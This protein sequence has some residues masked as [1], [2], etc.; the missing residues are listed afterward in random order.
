MFS[1]GAHEGNPDIG[2]GRRDRRMRLMHGNPHALD[3]PEAI[4]NGFGD[5]AGRGLDEP[6]AAGAKCL[7]RNLDDLV[8]AHGMRELIGAR[9]LRQ[10]D[11]EHEVEHKSL[12]DLRLMLHDAVIGMEG[13]SIDE[14]GVRHCALRTAAATRSA[15][16]VAATSWV[17]MID[18]PPATASR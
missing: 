17:R 18:A 3:L 9:S 2:K 11:V 5:R 16:T 1:A 14:H 4:E 12:P 10:I 6:V 8:V 7:A 13:K 15:C